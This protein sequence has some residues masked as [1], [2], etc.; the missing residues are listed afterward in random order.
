MKISSEKKI[1]LLHLMNDSKIITIIE[2]DE[3]EYNLQTR[4]PPNTK[5]IQEL[6]KVK[7]SW[8]QLSQHQMRNT[9]MG[10]KIPRNKD[11]PDAKKS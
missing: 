5:R 2:K 3:S 4:R 7:P 9:Q 1:R 6:Q 11:N 10:K 8:E